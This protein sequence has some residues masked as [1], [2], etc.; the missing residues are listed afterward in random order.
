MAK[1]KLQNFAEL[2]TFEHVIQ[3][4]FEKDDFDHPLKGKWASEFFKNNKPI[5]LELGCGKGEYTVALAQK[6]PER[7][8]LG[9]DIKGSRIWRGAKTALEENMQNVGF[10][11]TQIDRITNFFNESE[12]DEIWVT[13]PD[14]QPQKTR[15][16]KRLTSPPFLD[17]YRQLLKPGG[18]VHLK[19]D[20]AFL[21]AYTEEVIAEQ[22]LEVLRI[23]HDIDKD[24]PGDELLEIRTFYE[25]KFRQTGVPI[26]YVKF[27]L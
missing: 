2:E 3:H 18:I 5:T 23:S 1:R 11:R 26:N 10:I 17:R 12:V 6:H 8:F 22:N 9:V 27:K 4:P 25:M 19:T 15:T 24:F 20:S 21:F 16:R 13:F 7:N 14:P